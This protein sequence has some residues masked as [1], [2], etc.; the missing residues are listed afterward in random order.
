[1]S[2]QD[3]IREEM[4]EALRRRDEVRVSTLRL[5]LAA[6]RN[7]EIAREVPKGQ[8]DDAGVLGVIARE[9]KQR[10]ES[11][12]EYR[13]GQRP[14]LVAREEAELAVLQAYLPQQLTREE[15][16]DAARRVIQETGARGPQDLGKVMPKLMAELRG[17]ADGREVNAVVSELLRR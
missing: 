16:V 7:E 10:R 2:L 8:M 11:I 4:K 17:R 12:E 1:M 14:D 5:L 15:I 3:K 9:V 6:I 13:K